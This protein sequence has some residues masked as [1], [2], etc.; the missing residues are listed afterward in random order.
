[1][2][3]ELGEIYGAGEMKLKFGPPKAASTSQ[4]SIQPP[5]EGQS[6]DPALSGFDFQSFVFE[7]R[8][9]ERRRALLP[10]HALRR[11]PG[12]LRAKEDQQIE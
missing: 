12:Y 2:P 10:L 11:G 9:K 8:Y 7:F 3:A 5:G 6:W 1:M 4:A